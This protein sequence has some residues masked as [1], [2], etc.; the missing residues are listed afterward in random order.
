[1][2]NVGACEGTRGHA[3]GCEGMRGYAA[4]LPRVAHRNRERLQRMDCREAT[5]LCRYG[6]E[7]RPCEKGGLGEPASAGCEPRQ[8]GS[9]SRPEEK[10]R[11]KPK[12]GG[13]SEKRARCVGGSVSRKQ[14]STSGT[15]SPSSDADVAYGSHSAASTSLPPR[16]IP[17]A[18]A[19]PL[20]ACIRPRRPVSFSFDSKRW[21]SASDAR[22]Q[23]RYVDV[24]VEP[25]TR[26]HMTSATLGRA[27][28]AARSISAAA[29][30]T[31]M[32]G[33][34]P[35]VSESRPSCGVMSTSSSAPSDDS[36]PS[37]RAVRTRSFL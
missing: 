25:S 11:T 1:M 3:R 23:T 32:S 13:R 15:S 21:A 24:S 4:C 37:I 29:G 17:S 33:R 7:T 30:A 22:R 10:R 19:A 31:K 5:Q 16:S 34:R 36:L 18:Y 20:L 12:P 26:R 9:T 35:T 2:S 27:A 6:G 8:C 14:R 28:A